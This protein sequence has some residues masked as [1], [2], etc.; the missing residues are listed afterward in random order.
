MHLTR[1]QTNVHIHCI[2]ISSPDPKPNSTP[3]YMHTF[4]VANHRKGMGHAHLPMSVCSERL[5]CV[6]GGGL[7]GT[8]AGLLAGTDSY[9]LF[10][11]KFQYKL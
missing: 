5:T 7:V 11:W 3:S 10:G 4:S 6:C 8:K 9:L 1:A 2:D